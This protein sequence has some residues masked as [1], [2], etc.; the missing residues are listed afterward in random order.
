MQ[1][2]LLLTDG[3]L[4]ILNTQNYHGNLSSIQAYTQK[5]ELKIPKILIPNFATSF[6]W[7]ES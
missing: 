6:M 4:L 2:S 3:G 5:G 1:S 7:I